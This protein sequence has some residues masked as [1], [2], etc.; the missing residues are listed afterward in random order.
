[1]GTDY[2][3]SRNNQ[4]FS[5]SEPPP[6]EVTYIQSPFPENPYHSFP[7]AWFPG[8]H[9]GVCYVEWNCLEPRQWAPALGLGLWCPIWTSHL[10]FLG[11]TLCKMGSGCGYMWSA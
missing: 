2:L 8:A 10:N 11:L 4:M 5:D 3:G 7:M 9:L 1:M 6:S